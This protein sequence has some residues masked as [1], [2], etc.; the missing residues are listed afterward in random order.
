MMT[1]QLFLS[2]ILI[3]SIQAGLW[4]ILSGI[5]WGVWHALKNALSKRTVQVV[6]EILAPIITA[7]IN[8][9]SVQAKFKGM[10]DPAS[11]GGRWPTQ[12]ELRELAATV[13]AAARPQLKRLRGFALDMAEQEVLAGVR[14]FFARVGLRIGSGAASITDRPADG[15]SDDLAN[16]P[17]Q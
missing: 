17:A 4:L 3:P 11:P 13:E 1:Y 9:P 10:L 14:R 2:D 5:G 6:D 8:D 12:A 15:L 7:T 16:S